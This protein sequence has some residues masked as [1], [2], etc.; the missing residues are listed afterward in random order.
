M[1]TAQMNTESV[2]MLFLHASELTNLSIDS[3]HRLRDQA[4]GSPHALCY[5]QHRLSANCLRP[6]VTVQR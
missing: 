5:H 1:I 6:K 2:S 3:I 4:F